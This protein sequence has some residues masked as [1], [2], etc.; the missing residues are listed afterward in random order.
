MA[1]KVVAKVTIFSCS[2]ES[3]FQKLFSQYS[4]RA[5]E[6]FRSQEERAEK[7]RLGKKIVLRGSGGLQE[8][9]QVLPDG[10]VLI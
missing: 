9:L 4:G 7:E 6:T 5:Y 2:D 3:T 1:A 8:R 10:E